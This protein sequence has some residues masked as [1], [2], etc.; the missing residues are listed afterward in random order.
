MNRLKKTEVM[1][2]SLM[3]FMI[4]QPIVELDLYL[5]EFYNQLSILSLSTLL[6][7]VGVLFLGFLALLQSK[8]WKKEFILWSLYGVL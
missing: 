8:H 6:R 5:Q 3:I 2:Y 1:K 4:L 7:I